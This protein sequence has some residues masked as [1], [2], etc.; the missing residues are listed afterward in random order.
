MIT[1]IAFYLT[2]GRINKSELSEFST[3][4]YAFFSMVAYI[5][6]AGQDVMLIRWINSFI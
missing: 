1:G 5:L 4:A 2:T 6:A 3:N